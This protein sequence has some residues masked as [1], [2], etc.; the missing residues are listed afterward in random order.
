MILKVGVAVS[1]LTLYI[2]NMHI[3]LYMHVYYFNVRRFT[4]ILVLSSILPQVLVRLKIV[5]WVQIN[6]I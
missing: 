5:V 6:L 1:N 4:K 3:Y 2:L